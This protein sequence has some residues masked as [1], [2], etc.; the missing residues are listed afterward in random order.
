M[1][2]QYD[3]VKL[4]GRKVKMEARGSYPTMRPEGP[5]MNVPC[6]WIDP[7]F[8]N[9]CTGTYAIEDLVIVKRAA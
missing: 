5:S 7:E 8:G 9:L 1:I 3:I 2:N 4:K 6:V